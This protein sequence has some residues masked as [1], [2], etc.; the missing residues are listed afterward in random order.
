MAWDNSADN[1]SNPDPSETV[2]YGGPTTS[3]MMFGF[4]AY[5][6]AEPGYV[7]SEGS[8]FLSRQRNRNPERMK[9]MLKE[10]FGLDWDTMTEE[11]RDKVLQR[12]RAGRSGGQ[13]NPVG[14]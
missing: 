10:R 4:V 2:V 5:A 13:S 12:I 1:T 7:P 8:G 9:K 6:D 11:E 14:R 3:E